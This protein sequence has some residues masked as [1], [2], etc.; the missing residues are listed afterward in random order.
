VKLREVEA[1]NA[2]LKLV[3]AQQQ[4]QYSLPTS[5]IPVLLPA[6]ANSGT[7]PV[8]RFVEEVDQM[9]VE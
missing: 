6:L 1:E 7:H 9:F 5:T 8:S 4:Q 3:I 2:Q